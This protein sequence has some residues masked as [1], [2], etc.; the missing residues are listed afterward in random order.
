MKTMLP[1][2]KPIKRGRIGLYSIG[3]EAYWS[4]FLGLKEG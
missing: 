3:L 4:Q 1:P 2:I